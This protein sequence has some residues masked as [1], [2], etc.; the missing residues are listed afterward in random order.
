MIYKDGD[1]V[2]FAANRYHLGIVRAN[3]SSSTSDVL[4]QWMKTD[5]L[6][7]KPYDIVAEAFSR[8]PRPA[9]LE[10]RKRLLYDIFE[11]LPSEKPSYA[12]QQLWE[13]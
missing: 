1:I 12:P 2:L 8:L 4:V 6:W 5:P 9:Y 3:Q 10:T 7:M 13:E 11:P